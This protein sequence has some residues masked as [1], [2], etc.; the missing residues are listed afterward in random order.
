[1]VTT[2]IPLTRFGEYVASAKEIQ[3]RVSR[4]APAN[5]DL[6]PVVADLA[7]LAVRALEEVHQSIE[8]LALLLMALHPEVSRTLPLRKG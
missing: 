3:R 7:A 1:M 5:T 6:R 2:A 4:S 8:G